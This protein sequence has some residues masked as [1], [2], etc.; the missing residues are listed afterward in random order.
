MNINEKALKETFLRRPDAF[1]PNAGLFSSDVYYCIQRQDACVFFLSDRIVFD[2]AGPVSED[3]KQCTRAAVVLVFDGSNAGIAPRG[4]SRSEGVMNFYLGNDPT[5]YKDNVATY[6]EIMYQDLWPGVDLLLRCDGGKLKCNWTVGPGADPEQIVMSYLGADSLHL[7]D[8]GIVTVRHALGSMTDAYPVAFQELGGVKTE[9]ACSFCRKDE[10]TVGFETGSY[11]ETVPLYID[12]A[13]SYTTYLGGS[14]ADSINGISVGLTGDAYFVGQTA[15]ADFPTVAGAYQ[16]ALAGATDAFITKIASDG[17]SLIYSTYLGGSGTDAGLAITIDP[18]GAAYVTG[19]T[20]SADFPTVGPYQGA[21]AGAQDAFVSKLSP[22]GG[23]LTFSTY[24]GGAA[25]STTGRGIAVN[26]FGQTFVAGETSSASFPTTAGAFST[27]YSGGASDGFV[28]LLSSGGGSLL[29]STYL[30]GS[31]ADILYGLSLDSSDFVYVVGSTD[32]ADFP[33]TTGAFQTTLAGTQN[34][35]VTKFIGDLSAP[36]FSTYLGGAATDAALAVTVD[37]SFQ[38]CVTGSATSGDFPVTA[39]VFQTAYGGAGDAFTTKFS[40]DGASLIFSTYLGGSGADIGNAIALD[41]AG[42]VW[43]AGS[44]TSADFPTTPTVI[45]S[46]LT[47]TQDWFISLLSADAAT[48]LVSYYL[49]GTST[50]SAEAIAV[51]AQ[52]AVYVA[53]STSS[54]DFPVSGGAFQTVYG[55]GAT[56]GAATKAN[57]ATF[58]NASVTIMQMTT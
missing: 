56:D 46:S 44:T 13:V 11:D 41:A 33:T 42:H 58:K 27:A 35:F 55:G 57:F 20:T 15:S 2:F 10:M 38:A 28:S 4:L 23:A 1:V 52:G 36:V 24:L 7:D 9:T 8:E 26:I 12:P 18:S 3:T 48:L 30:G 5:Q 31:G 25:G 16:A 49:G 17:A 29:V 51:D 14:A 19:S 40:L 37:S 53:G 45:T 34:A 22:N 54:A 39:G 43:L 47:G 50:Q 21:L 6:Q 32:S